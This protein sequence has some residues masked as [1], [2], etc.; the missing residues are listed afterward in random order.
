MLLHLKRLQPPA[1]NNLDTALLDS[2]S[3]TGQI[4]F[5]KPL[6]K[7]ALQVPLLTW[8]RAC[9]TLLAKPKFHNSPPAWLVN[10]QDE[11]D[12]EKPLSRPTNVIASAP[13]HVQEDEEGAGTRL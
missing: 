1:Y 2:T 5:T 12:V 13:G 7:A 10:Q 6:D 4:D 9:H 3:L 8:D 11:T